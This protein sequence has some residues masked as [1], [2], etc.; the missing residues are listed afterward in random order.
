MSDAKPL[1]LHVPEPLSRPGDKPDFSYIEVPA[2]GATRLSELVCHCL[3]FQ[4]PLRW[5]AYIGRDF[6][7]PQ[8]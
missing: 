5:S 1:S 7:L 4:L 3:R 8:Q 6:S 2:A